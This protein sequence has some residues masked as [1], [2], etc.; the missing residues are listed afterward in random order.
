MPGLTEQG[1]GRAGTPTP[2]HGPCKTRRPSLPAVNM[3]SV[4]EGT[5]ALTQDGAFL[6]NKKGLLQIKNVAD[7]NTECKIDAISQK[8]EQQANGEKHGSDMDTDIR[9]S[10]HED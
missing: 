10:V 5:V 6:K 1:R 4:S 8:V 2:H 9:G 7:K 3:L